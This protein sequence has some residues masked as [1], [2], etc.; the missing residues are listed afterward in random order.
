MVK[1]LFS[2]K[3]VLILVALAVFAASCGGSG[4]SAEADNDGGVDDEVFV[5][6][7]EPLEPSEDSD[8][9]EPEESPAASTELSDVQS[10]PTAGSEAVPVDFIESEELPTG[11]SEVMAAQRALFTTVNTAGPN[12][13]PATEQYLIDVVTH[14]DIIWS[15]FF[16]QHGM[17]VPTVFYETVMPGEVAVSD[18]NLTIT[19]DH[20]NAYYCRVDSYT[21]ENGFR[22]DGSML[23]PVT[24]FARMFEGNMLN[25]PGVPYRIG[26]FAAAVVVAHEMG[27]SIAHEFEIYYANN[28]QAGTYI[29]KPT[30]VN[31]ELIADCFAGVWAY[32]VFLDNLLDV[33]DIDEGVS[34]LETVGGDGVTHPPSSDRRSAFLIGYLG[35]Q[36]DARPG[37]PANCINAFWY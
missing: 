17:Q 34:A 36:A 20:P 11:A 12:D 37:V 4:T 9:P 29:P 24:T 2:K 33:G 19:H 35:S 26:D 21:D 28:Y 15:N 16:A 23:L 30:G 27:H 14:A 1:L 10:D 18:C 25:K 32:S 6:P 5:P 13:L 8:D 22:Y 31:I 7:E 3:F